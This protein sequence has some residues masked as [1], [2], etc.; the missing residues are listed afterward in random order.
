[1]IHA[2]LAAPASHELHHELHNEPPHEPPHEHSLAELVERRVHRYFGSMGEGLADTGLYIRI[3]A[4]IE[5]PL[6]LATLHHT[7]GNQIKA[8]QILGLNRNTLRKK[9]KELNISPLRADYKTLP[10]HQ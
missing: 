2:L 8:A 9:I 3:L 5:K 7:S 10:K 1:M 6:I 4:E